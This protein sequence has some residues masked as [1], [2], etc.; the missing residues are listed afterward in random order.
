MGGRTS[1]GSVVNR[2][3]FQSAIREKR[4]PQG[5]V[6]LKQGSSPFCSLTM[7]PPRA[8]T[9]GLSRCVWNR[10]ATL[11]RDIRRA[12]ARKAGREGEERG[13]SPLKQP[14]DWSVTGICVCIVP[15]GRAEG[16][17]A[18]PP[19]ASGIRGCTKP[20]AQ[21]APWNLGQVMA[22]AAAPPSRSANRRAC[23]RSS[24]PAPRRAG[25]R[26]PDWCSVGPTGAPAVT[27]ARQSALGGGGPPEDADPAGR[28]CKEWNF[29]ES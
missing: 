28:A 8:R 14:Q 9:D 2:R 27:A 18:P 25:L 10:V 13:C 29:G 5:R 4:Q 19:P 6:S 17:E 23:C 22:V 16:G 20:E 7:P 15:N 11:L 21:S 3:P 12:Q 24:G 26:P 1:D